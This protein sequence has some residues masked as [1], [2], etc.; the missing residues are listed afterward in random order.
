MQDHKKPQP[1]EVLIISFDGYSDIWNISISSMLENWPDCPYRINLLT[2]EKTFPDPKIR[3][4]VIGKDLDWSSNLLVGL[5]KLNCDYVLTIFE[6]LI[7]SEPVNT[8]LIQ[9]FVSTCIGSGYEYLRLRPSPPP[10]GN[11]YP[12][13]GSIKG[14]AAY[15]VSLCTSIVRRATLMHLLKRGENAWEFEKYGSL[16]SQQYKHFY[17]TYQQVIPYINAI[18][19]GRWNPSMLETLKEEGIDYKQRG[20]FQ[21]EKKTDALVH[22]KHFIVFSLMPVFIRKLYYAVRKKFK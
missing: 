14:G 12:A 22:I 9:E 13:Y 20:V 11:E 2:N 17:S 1:I 18:E 21:M 4:L 16:R 5:E 3:S 6:D 7:L 8:P 19:K 10:D 15:R